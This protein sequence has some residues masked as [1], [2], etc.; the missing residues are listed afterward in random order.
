MAPLYNKKIALFLKWAY[1]KSDKL[2]AISKFTKDEIIKKVS[3][4]NIEVLE[5]GVDYNKFYQ[6]HDV[7]EEDFIISVGGLK[8]RKGYH[9]AIPAFAMA[10]KNNPNL[11]YKIVGDQGDVRYF[12]L[13][14]ELVKKYNIED[15]VEFLSGI[16]D[17]QLTELYKQAKIFVLPSVNM[18]HNFEGFGLVFLEAA[19]AGLPVIGTLG[20]GIE[21]SVKNGFNGIL[22]EQENIE[23]TAQAINTMMGDKKR[24]EQMSQNSYKWAK[25]HDWPIIID[26]YINLYNQL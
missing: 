2:L 6:K 16:S 12:N 20:N 23:G 14:K 3:L 22:V 17:E 4:D 18:D 15:S 25:D 24:W 1:R 26:K 11:K 9:I 8:S 13:L 7:V 19:A 21:D 10:K 5:L